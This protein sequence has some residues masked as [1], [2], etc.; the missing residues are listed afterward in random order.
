MNVTR[1]LAIDKVQRQIWI[2]FNLTRAVTDRDTD[3]LA[4]ALKSYG[5]K[6]NCIATAPSGR[7]G[8]TFDHIS[9]ALPY[10]AH[11]FGLEEKY[12]I[13]KSAKLAIEQIVGEKVAAG[14]QAKRLFCG[15]LAITQLYQNEKKEAVHAS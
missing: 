10:P 11:V 8:K 2:G 9:I 13:F 12:E 7:L 1:I 14:F 15:N 5:I 4:S 3:A 6:H